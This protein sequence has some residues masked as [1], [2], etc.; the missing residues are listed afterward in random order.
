[1][2][3][4]ADFW[5]A[6]SQCTS[7]ANFPSVPLSSPR[8]PP[9]VP[10]SPPRIAQRYRCQVPRNPQ[11]YRCQS[12]TNRYRYRSS[13]DLSSPSKVPDRFYPK[14]PPRS[15]T[16]PRRLS[17]RPVGSVHTG[18]HGDR[19]EN[20][21]GLKINFR[22]SPCHL[23]V[24][25]PVNLSPSLSASVPGFRRTIVPAACRTG[26]PQGLPAAGRPTAV[27]TR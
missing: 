23:S 24:A 5:D 6:R 11:R 10:L 19:T 22:G 16:R 1:M 4:P 9:T 20:H 17:C 7:V 25:L 3:R 18:N 14:H 27:S 26:A 21:G 13:S 8:R 12:P 15:T 2:D